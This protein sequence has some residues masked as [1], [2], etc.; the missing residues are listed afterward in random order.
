MQGRR[1]LWKR[2]DGP[3]LIDE[4]NAQ[5]KNLEQQI[6]EAGVEL[7]KMEANAEQ[8]QSEYT[9]LMNWA[10]LYDNC[11]FDA[12]KNDGRSVCESG[13]VPAVLAYMEKAGPAM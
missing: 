12:K 11:T 10:E 4:T 1:K 7:Q 13:K 2:E 9:Q 6:S 8:V 3:S 5:L